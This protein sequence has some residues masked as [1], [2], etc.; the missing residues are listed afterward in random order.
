MS[1]QIDGDRLRGGR[2]PRGGRVAGRRSSPTT[3]S[4]DVEHLAAALRRFPGDGGAIG[5]VAIDEDFFVIV[6]VAGPS[7]RIL[8]SDITAADEWELA[9]SAVEHLGLPEPEDDDDQV[10]AGDLDI[11]G[12]LGMGA[13]DMAVLLDDFDLYP[14]EML[15]DVAR[16]LGFGP[17][18]DEAVGL[19]LRLTAPTA[20]ARRGTTSRCAPPSTRRALALAS[21]D[22]PIGAVVL[23]ADRRGDRPRAQ[24]PRARR[25]PD[26]PR[27]AG[28]AS[29]RPRR[30]I[31]EWRLDRLH[32]RGH[33]RAVHDVRRRDRA[34]PGST[35][36]CSGRTTPRPAPSD[37][38]GTSSA[39]AGSTTARRWSAACSPTSAGACWTIS[40][41]TNASGSLSRGGVSERPK[42]HAS[43]ACV[44]ASPPWVQIP[45]PPPAC[46]SR[47]ARAGRAETPRRCRSGRG[48][49]RSG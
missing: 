34:A 44:G 10:P 21:A 35:A 3:S 16:R 39:T 17:L 38:S 33:P 26:R 7:V 2:L 40:S 25:R 13:M 29:A 11:L 48:P 20:G 15:S 18:F 8:L 31:G 4:T 42:E 30:A 9:R 49:V 24:R 14:D 19:T 28:R 6:R 27:R 22:V 45:P 47:R 32:P 46:R 23:D 12:D 5:L 1:E 43:K 41:P 37:R 36:W